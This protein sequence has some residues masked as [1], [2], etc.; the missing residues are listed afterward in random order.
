MA[1]LVAGI[2]V[3][4]AQAYGTDAEYINWAALSGAE[5]G[6]DEAARDVERFNAF[7]Y[8][9]SLRDRYQGKKTESEGAQFPRSG[10]YIDGD[11]FD[12]QLVPDLVKRAEFELAIQYHRDSVLVSSGVSE[13]VKR[14]KV[15]VLEVEYFDGGS[16]QSI[17]TGKADVYLKPLYSSPSISSRMSRV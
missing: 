5:V 17:S 12:D 3:V 2:G 6:A 14:E 10:L 8:I 9:E 7:N 1:L 16:S 4:G 15:D 13:N 11:L